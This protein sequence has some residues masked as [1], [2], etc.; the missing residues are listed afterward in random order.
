MPEMSRK[1]LRPYQKSS[2]AKHYDFGA[3]IVHKDAP[4]HFTFEM[5]GRREPIKIVEPKI[6]LPF[7]S[8]TRLLVDIED[9]RWCDVVFRFEPERP[10][11]YRLIFATWKMINYANDAL[12]MAFGDP[13]G[14]K[15]S[16]PLIHRMTIVE[17]GH[18]NAW[19]E[20][21]RGKARLHIHY[22]KGRRIPP[23]TAV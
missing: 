16:R 21:S 2:E 15:E 10:R 11:P 20:M 9:K 3:P 6:D 12:Y 1:V 18:V 8:G 17:M 22:T 19:I 14:R 13:P 5:D 7:S 4:L 23:K